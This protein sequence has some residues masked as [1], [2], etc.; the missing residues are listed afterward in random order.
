[1]AQLLKGQVTLRSELVQAVKYDYAHAKTST[2]VACN[3]INSNANTMTQAS[4][5]R[6]NKGLLDWIRFNELDRRHAKIECAYGTTFEWIFQPSTEDQYSSFGPWLESQT[7]TLYWIAGKPAAGKSTLM[8]FLHHDPRTIEHLKAWAADK[9]LITC[10]FFFWNSGEQIQRSMEGMI[11]TLLYTALQ[12]QPELWSALFPSKMQEYIMFTDPW[13]GPISSEEIEQAFESLIKRAG[14]RY[15]LFFFIDGLDEFDGGPQKL[16]SLMKTL[17][18]DHVKICVSSRP[19]T[20]FEDAFQQR[21]SLRLERLTGDDIEHYVHSQFANSIGFQDRQRESPVEAQ[22][23]VE[24]VILKA[25]GVF[26]WVKLVTESLLEGCSDGERVQELQNRLR[27]LPVGLEALFGTILAQV[28]DGY[29]EHAARMLLITRSAVNQL[30]LLTFSYADDPSLEDVTNM[31]PVASDPAQIDARARNMRRRLKSYTK[32]LLEAEPEP[33]QPIP[34]AKVGYLHRTV[35][36]YIERSDVWPAF[37]GMAGETF[38][39]HA[40]ICLARIMRLKTYSSYSLRHTNG[41]SINM[42]WTNVLGAVDYA[43]LSDPGNKSGLQVTLLTQLDAVVS[44]LTVRHRSLFR[45]QQDQYGSTAFASLAVALQLKDYVQFLFSKEHLRSKISALDMRVMLQQALLDYNHL[46]KMQNRSENFSIL[47]STPDL[48]L[49]KFL[50]DHGGDPNLMTVENTETGW[51]E[52][53]LSLWETHVRHRNRGTVYWADISIFLLEHGADPAVFD[54]SVP[55]VPYKVAAL[56]RAKQDSRKRS[57]TKRF[58]NVFTRVSG[59][60]PTTH[61]RTSTLRAHQVH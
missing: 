28:K 50:I 17:I 49:V 40:R 55:N 52:S 34:D 1:M 16:V 51:I 56:A 54:G 15:K 41:E 58:E 7:E 44:A 3:A 9:M 29:R 6:F 18:S 12:Q 30:D 20:E 4:L 24:N 2:D 22:Q 61:A 46:A 26:L 35:R 36:S 32:G 60:K 5:Q 31:L 57:L 23:L 13:L 25:S 38:N 19:W 37:L 33:D 53:T 45:S 39:P 10:A 11:R 47:H 8:K 43:V 14:E 27:D 48:D 59:R 21:P 42:F